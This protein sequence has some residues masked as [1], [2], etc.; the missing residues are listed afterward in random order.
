[1]VCLYGVPNPLTSAIDHQTIR[2]SGIK[3]FASLNLASASL[4]RS[5]EWPTTYTDVMDID[6]KAKK[7]IRHK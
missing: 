4:A 6:A 2:V 1:M 3:R 5:I 7:K